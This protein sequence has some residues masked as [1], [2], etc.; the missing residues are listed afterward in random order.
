M[1]VNLRQAI[2]QMGD[3]PRQP[4]ARHRARPGQAE[5]LI[6]RGDAG[7]GEAAAQGARE[8]RG[9]RHGA[10]CA[11]L[12]DRGQERACGSSGT[13]APCTPWRLPQLHHQPGDGGMQMKMLVGVD[14]I[15][16]Q[17]GGGEG[18]ELRFDLR[19]QLAAHLG[20]KEHRRARPR[21]VGAEI[22]RLHPP[23]RALRLRGRTGLPST[24]TRCRPTRRR[25]HRLGAAHRIGGGRARHHQA[26]GG[27]NAV[28]DGRVRPR[29]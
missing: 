19:F 18:G 25:R 6:G 17:A 1:H 14:M 16:R 9:Q 28:A 20:Q 13:R 27:E 7:A 24:S 10:G 15:E 12:F 2:G 4:L 23:G 22:A 8:R 11:M 3:Q 26:G 5:H 29:R 21:H